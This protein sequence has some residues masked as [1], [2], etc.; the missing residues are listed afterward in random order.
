MNALSNVT[1]PLGL[2]TPAAGGDTILIEI[3]PDKVGQVI[4]SK[5]AII[6]EIQT[7]TGA[8][9]FV[10]QDFPEGVN[11][12]VNITGTTP[13][14]KAAAE[15]VNLIIEHGPT[16]IHVNSLTGGPTLTSVLECTQTQVLKFLL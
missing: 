9:A 12:Q 2:A 14:V 3:S 10:N 13:Q 6:Q 8:K 1:F 15:L 11:R 5:G 16:A 7:R 4:G